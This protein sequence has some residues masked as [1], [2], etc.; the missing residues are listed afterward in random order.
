MFGL[1]AQ[2]FVDIDISERNFEDILV[3]CDWSADVKFQKVH[4]I[5]PNNKVVS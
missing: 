3:E 2:I 4:Q 5:L 1:Y